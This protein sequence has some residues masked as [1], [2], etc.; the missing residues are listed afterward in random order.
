MIKNLDIVNSEIISKKGKRTLVRTVLAALITTMTLSGCSGKND[1]KIPVNNPI[2]NTTNDEKTIVVNIDNLLE[3]AG[4]DIELYDEIISEKISFT[5]E[6]FQSLK[7]VIEDAETIYPYS[8]IFNVEKAYE[9]YKNLPVQKE[10]KS[11]INLNELSLDE[12]YKLVKENNKKH[13]D[14]E[15]KASNNKKELEED[16][17]K[18]ACEVVYQ[19]IKNEI[20]A[21]PHKEKLDEMAYTIENLCIFESPAGKDSLKNGSVTDNNCLYLTPIMIENAKSLVG[22]PLMFE[23]VV[24]HE[25]IHLLQKTNRDEK[26]V[27][28]KFGFNYS[29]DELEVNPLNLMWFIEASAEQ[30]ATNYYNEKPAT[31]LS[32]VDYLNSLNLALIT[33]ESVPSYGVP[34]LSYQ[35]SL[36]VVFDTF[37]CDTYEKQIEFLNM[38]AS[39]N[40]VLEESNELLDK[41]STT[42]EKSSNSDFLKAYMNKNNKN[43]LTEEEISL[44][45]LELENSSWQTITKYFYFNLSQKLTDNTADLNEVFTIISLYEANLNKSLDY[46]KE[47]KNF[48]LKEFMKLYLNIQNEFFEQ[49]ALSNNFSVDGIKE[50][51]KIFNETI[52]MPKNSLLTGVE[53][54]NTFQM[55]L[56]GEADK[57]EQFT[58]CYEENMFKKTTS[59]SEIAEKIIELEKTK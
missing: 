44:L 32:K 34:M 28:N 46:T 27:E 59:V 4:I 30:L 7:T 33:N 52:L 2:T 36:E 53:R 56:I 10:N 23:I 43:I 29:F 3:N 39:I 55:D 21:N 22:V 24:F 57:N 50:S 19:A 13:N 37:D 1:Y 41:S 12:L 54:I 48:H 18:D 58:K 6:N 49:I 20:K 51:Y 16:Y 15:T 17:L 26:T 38:M 8:E 42:F 5:E 45:K 11:S 25:T 35:S 31:Y 14:R 9:K 40:V 47:N